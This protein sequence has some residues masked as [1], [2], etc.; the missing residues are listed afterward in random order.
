MF[1]MAVRQLLSSLN[2]IPDDERSPYDRALQRELQ[3]LLE[4][5][6]RIRQASGLDTATR[7]TFGQSV[8]NA[9]VQAI[10][11]TAGLRTLTMGAGSF[12]ELTKGAGAFGEFGTVIDT[13][14]GLWPQDR[15]TRC[16]KRDC[17]QK[18]I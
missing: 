7:R 15:W 16:P 4:M 11:R 12:G 17:P 14:P 10:G 5:T 8:A 6:E 18:G 13:G 1:P 9:A 3:A 2:E